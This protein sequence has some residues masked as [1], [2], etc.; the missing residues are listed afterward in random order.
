MSALSTRIANL[1]SEQRR[2]FEQRLRSAA[3]AVMRPSPDGDDANISYPE[4]RCLHEMVERQ[5]GQ[6]P[7]AVAVVFERERITY[8]ELNDRAN[9]LA[10][11]LRASGV[12]PEVVVGVC[13]ERSIEMVV[14]LLGILKAGGAYLP[15]DPEYPLERISFMAR[16]GRIRLLLTQRELAERLDL[17]GEAPGLDV[18]TLD[19]GWGQVAAFPTTNPPNTVSPDNLAY[20][21][22]TSG[23]TGRPKGSMLHHRGICNRLAWM[24]HAYQLGAAD[25]VLQKTS[26]SFDVS[27][28]EFFWPLMTGARLVMARPG[29]HRDGAYLAEVI[30]RERVTVLHFVPSMLQAWLPERGVEECRSLRLVVCSGEALGAGLRRRV[31]ERMDWVE[32]ENLYGP[33]EA[34]VDVTRWSCRLGGEVKEVPIGRPIWN[35]QMYVLGRELELLPAGAT[36]ELYIG[37]VQLAR[38]YAGRPDLTAERFIPHPYG[39][40]GGERLYRTGDLG[41]YS[42]DGEIEYLGRVDEQVKIR[43]YRIELGEVE[44]ALAAEERV[45]ACVAVAR[46]DE[47]GHKRLVAYVVFE[48]EVPETTTAALVRELR[49]RLLKSLPE[50]MA[51]SA[52]IFM[53]QLPLTA[54]G[55]VNRR[56]LPAPDWSQLSRP[57][58]YAPPRTAAEATL[59]GVWA[60]VLGLERVGIR[61]NFFDLGGDSI[62]SIQIVARAASAGLRL[63]PKQLFQH[64]TVEALA[65]AA[66]AEGAGAEGAAAWAEQGEVTGPVALT[67]IQRRFFEQERARPEHFNQSVML[68][69]RADVRAVELREAVAALVRHHDALRLR[70]RRDED[71]R[72]HQ[73]NAAFDGGDG[74]ASVFHEVDLGAVGEAERRAALEAAAGQAQRSLS[75][76]DGPLL[77]ALLV[78]RGEGE[79]PRLL[80]VIHHL[81]VD[82][83]SWRI[84]LEDLRSA[85]GQACGGRAVRLPAK[86]S[87]YQQWAALLAEYAAGGRAEAEARYWRGRAWASAGRLPRDREGGRNRRAD[88]RQAVVA[89]SR[90]QTGWLLQEAPAAYRTRIQ[91]LLLA[92]LAAVLAE[93]AGGEAVA[94][95]LEG[96]GREEAVGG[97]DVTRTV[98][99]FTSVYPVLLRAGRGAGPGELIKGIKEQLSG[100]PEGGLA[101]GAWRYLGAE[102]EQVGPREAEAEVVFNYLG[103]LDQVLGG[104]AAGDERRAG[105]ELF[106]GAAGEATGEGED[107]EAERGWAHEINGAVAGG[108]LELRWSYSGEQYEA[109]TVE[110]LAG[111]Y[112]AELIRLIEHCREEGAGGRTPSDFPLARLTQAEVDRLVGD[113]RAVEDIYP[114]TPMQQGLLFHAL[115]AP[116]A[117]FYHQQVSCE[118]GGGFEAGLFVGAWREVMGRHAILRTGFV[119]EGVEEPLQVVYRDAE[120]PVGEYDWRG[121][122]EAEQA[123][124]WERLLA[125][126]RERGFEPGRAPLMRLALARVGEGGYRLLWSHH[127][128]LLDGWC[129]AL[130]IKQV[131]SAYER[132][133]GGGESGESAEDEGSRPY[134]D[135]IAWLRRQDLGQAEAYWRETLRGF[136]Q[137]T[138]I[139]ERKRKGPRR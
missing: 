64:Q 69:L 63:T 29:G 45:R 40:R 101:Y 35:T 27:V 24:Q 118:M 126:D 52:I 21:I 4:H 76:S 70:F 25:A 93:W 125:E 130:V 68:R 17:D 109:A 55:K 51:P 50:Y 73:F 9:Q 98:G 115:Y 46:E 31:E 91:E 5:V 84:L 22:Y 105:A 48:N 43:G 53:E 94:V 57:L 33:T 108:R 131:F 62:L 20:V 124:R 82:G 107:P 106:L 71:G 100:V 19:A 89:L 134:R 85:Y 10:H 77:R 119:W 59:A 49:A 117:G 86:T 30:R 38:G 32:L 99:W 28:W 133:R 129:L 36:G 138:L 139:L 13:V 23:S 14:G 34:S 87:S 44:A 81:A 95:E 47:S 67:P 120:M 72:W 127:H 121:E 135:Y 112:Q 96:H 66:G 103:Q 56:A 16:D 15:I 8:R 12:G 26:F 78:R 137:P 122:G 61:D 42:K 65:R 92:A 90:E 102:G 104:G 97:A 74:A 132:L 136:Q 60:D 83:V 41:R 58:G 7:D 111:R 11:F 80:L 75:L 113:G 79:E 3:A 39:T 123:G 1:T 128:L 110:R 88:A 6:S 114:V 37:G 2:A 54:S 116:A 18:F